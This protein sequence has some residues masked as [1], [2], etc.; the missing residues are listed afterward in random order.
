[1]ESPFSAF[2]STNFVPTDV[3]CDDIRAFLRGPRT[4]LADIT[5]EIARLQS[6]L[7]EAMH[8][9]DE[10]QGFIN[11]H[12]ALVSPVRRLPDDIMQE[13]FLAARPSDRN[14]AMTS[15]EAPLL[16]CRICKSWRTIAL[17]TPSL[18]SSLHIVVPSLS[19]LPQLTEKA[20]TWLGRSGVVP[21]DISLLYSRTSDVHRDISPLT[22]ILLG[23]SRR[24]QNMELAL[25]DGRA[26]AS[27]TADDVPLLQKF[28]FHDA[29][30]NV[31]RTTAPLTFL[32]APSLRSLEC[33][34]VHYILDSPISWGT[35]TQLVSEY[36]LSYHDAFRIL[37]QCPLL[38]TCELVV[39]GRRSRPDDIAWHNSSAKTIS[40]PNVRHFSVKHYRIASNPASHFF[41]HLLLP[42]LRYFHCH[43]FDGP[44]FPRAQL[45]FPQGAFNLQCVKIDVRKFTSSLLHAA[46]SEIPSVEELHIAH[47]PC[48]DNGHCDAQFLKHLIPPQD[49]VTSVICPR[50]RC[51]ELKNFRGVSDDLLVEFILSR[52]RSLLAPRIAFPLPDVVPLERFTCALQRPMYRNIQA[53]LHPHIGDV[54]IIL[55]YEALPWLPYSPLEGFPEDPV[56]Q[57][58]S[59]S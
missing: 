56:N 6:L 28:K 9:R 34:S 17:T 47:E 37:N 50:L 25:T 51:L 31:R 35:L 53:E 43:S 26:F 38:E 36:L 27:L 32:G 20:T 22:S 24:W 12:T 15:D 23:V 11:V 48:N 3:E 46:L 4:K 5:E 13:I 14:P 45:L 39:H 58:R 33:R 49:T 7:N 16:L 42:A 1:M 41:N 44:S 2:L 57:L 54:E 21:L 8:Q 19:A 10:L 59:T 55:T 52:T 40:L 30:D 29:A 18:W